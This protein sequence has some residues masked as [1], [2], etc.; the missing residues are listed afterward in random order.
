MTKKLASNI[1]TQRHFTKEDIQER[2][3]VLADYCSKRW[4]SE[5]ATEG[6]L[7]VLAVDEEVEI[8]NG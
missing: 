1:D 4:W 6:P 5:R 2:T 8:S 7:T 3:K